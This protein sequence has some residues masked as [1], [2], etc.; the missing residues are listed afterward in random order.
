[1]GF[2]YNCGDGWLINV[3]NLDFVKPYH[4]EGDSHPYRLGYYFSGSQRFASNFDT[5]RERNKAI[6]DLL[7][8]IPTLVVKQDESQSYT[9]S[10]AGSVTGSSI[11][12][13]TSIDELIGDRADEYTIPEAQSIFK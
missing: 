3:L 1:M 10:L 12:A 9:I 13:V 2:L 5:E 8:F 11:P 4:V 7:D 6:A